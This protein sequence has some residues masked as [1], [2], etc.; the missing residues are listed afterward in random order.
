MVASLPS[1]VPTCSS[2]QKIQGR[3]KT[4]ALLFRF[5]YGLQALPCSEWLALALA[6]AS[7]MYSP[8]LV[9]PYH[10]SLG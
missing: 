9:L 10:L 6:S 8:Y 4:P 1:A 3:R 7:L 2:L 5:D